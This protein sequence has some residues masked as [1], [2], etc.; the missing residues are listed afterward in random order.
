MYILY[1]YII[2]G[3]TISSII[4]LFPNFLYIFC[5][6]SLFNLNFNN[7]F[8]NFV[9]EFYPQKY[10]LTHERINVIYTCDNYRNDN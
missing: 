9:Q 6:F 3:I 4:D 2:T 10:V 5:P 1:Q 7:M 8:L